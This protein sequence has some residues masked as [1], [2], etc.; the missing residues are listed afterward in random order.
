M[1]IVA[2]ADTHDQ[3]R[4]ISIPPCDVFVHAGDFTCHKVPQIEKYEDFAAWLNEIPAKYKVIV[5]GNHDIFCEKNRDDFVKMLGPNVFYLCDSWAKIEGIKFYGMPHVLKW[6]DWAFNIGE[7]AM[8]ELC[9]KIPTDVD[10][11]VTHCPPKY[12]M[13]IGDFGA[14]L[15]SEALRKG[16]EKAK[17]KYHI[18]GHAHNCYG[19][20][21]VNDITYVNC[22]QT[23]EGNIPR[24]RP[25]V[26]EV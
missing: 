9:E 20:V 4:H 17:P 16:V 19:T 25:Y 6:G 2:V 24:Y 3:H 10:I 12:I 14:Q 7:V 23:W 15:G 11:L 8:D 21:V 1:K 13:E 5:A 26:F 22:S 18:F